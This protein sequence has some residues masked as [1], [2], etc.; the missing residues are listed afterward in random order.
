[1]KRTAAN[2]LSEL[3]RRRA[4]KGL[5]TAAQEVNNKDKPDIEV[6]S[7][8]SDHSSDKLSEPP[9]S[10]SRS[11]SSQFQSQSQP[12]A[13]HQRQSQFQSQLQSQPQSQPQSRPAKKLFKERQKARSLS[14]SEKAPDVS[15]ILN[16]KTFFEASLIYENTDTRTVSGVQQVFLSE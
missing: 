7:D 8:E 15:Y 4:P 14:S 16:T 5:F 11:Q 3:T 9:T 1:M 12:Q 2:S 13:W 6:L 10:A